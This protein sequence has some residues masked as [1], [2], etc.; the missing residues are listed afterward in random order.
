MSGLESSVASFVK[1]AVLEMA[2]T[3]GCCKAL[4]AAIAPGVEQ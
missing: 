1:V 2:S 3:A 4:V